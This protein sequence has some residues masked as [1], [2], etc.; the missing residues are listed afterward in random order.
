MSSLRISNT[1]LNGWSPGVLCRG[2]VRQDLL[3]NTGHPCLTHSEM[4]HSRMRGHY[5]G[6][7]C[8]M[9]LAQKGWTV[10][11][12]NRF[13]HEKGKEENTALVNRRPGA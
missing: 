7:L 4:P 9:W 1:P 6:C 12:L 3:R 8:D 5:H 2:S 13:R 10:T 11:F